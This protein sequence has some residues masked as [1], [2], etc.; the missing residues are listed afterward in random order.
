MIKNERKATK[1]SEGI[2]RVAS[3]SEDTIVSC[4]DGV[5]G[6]I[7][8]SGAFGVM[9]NHRIWKDRQ[10]DWIMDGQRKKNSI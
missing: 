7:R 6:K 2:E 1:A 8:T 5:R 3:S 4:I 10:C 9:R